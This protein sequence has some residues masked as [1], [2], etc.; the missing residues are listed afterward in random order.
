MWAITIAHKK[1]FTIALLHKKLSNTVVKTKLIGCNS[2]TKV[3]SFKMHTKATYLSILCITG[4]Y[5]DSQNARKLMNCLTN[6]IV[7]AQF[8]PYN[9]LLKWTKWFDIRLVC[10]N[11][12]MDGSLDDSLG[13]VGHI[14]LCIQTKHFTRA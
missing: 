6:I 13:G 3:V 10:P 14:P 8:N 2:Q 5:I 12:D 9:Q 7:A 1:K 4:S 11:S